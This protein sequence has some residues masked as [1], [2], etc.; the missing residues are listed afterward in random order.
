MMRLCVYVCGVCVVVSVCERAS[1][2]A[3]LNLCDFSRS[4]V[5]NFQRNADRE[6]KM[7]LAQLLDHA[8]QRARQLEEALKAAGVTVPPP[9][10]VDGPD[11][12]VPPPAKGKTG[13][14]FG[15]G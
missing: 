3:C 13:G 2:A 12:P 14:R 10:A 8:A 11:P 1:M 5:L 6:M 15:R 7:K 9:P 4:Q